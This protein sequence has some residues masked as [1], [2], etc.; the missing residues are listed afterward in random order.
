MTGDLRE[1][2]LAVVRERGPISGNAVV[3][4]VRGHRA[5]VL[6]ALRACEAAGLVRSTPDGWKAV[7]TT[8]EP[9][10]NHGHGVN[11]ADPSGRGLLIGLEAPAC[12]DAE[13]RRHDWAMPGATV[14]ICGVC[15]PP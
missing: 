4:T 11:A 8:R 3:A 6:A 7:G 13:H 10:R 9:P 14:W 12:R 15:F 1:Q 2:V 5:D